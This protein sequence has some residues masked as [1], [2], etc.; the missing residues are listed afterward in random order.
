MRLLTVLYLALTV[1]HLAS[2][3]LYLE[4][5][6]LY[7]ALTVLCLALTVLYR[8][9]AGIRDRAAGRVRVG[10]PDR[11]VL[12]APP[13]RDGLLRPQPLPGPHPTPYTLNPPCWKHLR[14]HGLA[15]ARGISPF[16]DL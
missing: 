3:V 13:R 1:L 16:I 5:T 10:A 6:V 12:D 11:P 2:T 9:G 14:L 15:R 8:A 7:L 4:M